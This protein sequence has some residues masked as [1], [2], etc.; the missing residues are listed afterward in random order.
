M[1]LVYILRTISHSLM[2]YVYGGGTEF[3]G[4][5]MVSQK[6]HKKIRTLISHVSLI[7]D[8]SNIHHL[9]PWLYQKKKSC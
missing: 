5:V 3:H 4:Y 9:A 2:M 6:Q 8:F 7:P 1:T